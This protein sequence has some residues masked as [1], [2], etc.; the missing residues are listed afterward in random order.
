MTSVSIALRP[1][2]TA[3][4]PAV[5]CGVRGYDLGHVAYSAPLGGNYTTCDSL[6][7]LRQKCQSFAFSST[8]CFLYDVS[9]SINFRKDSSSPFWFYEQPCVVDEASA[10]A[11]IASSS[12]SSSLS[13]SSSSSKSSATRNRSAWFYVSQLLMLSALF[14]LSR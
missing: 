13:S 6:C 3:S 5:T 2:S 12:S 7:S 9:L 4:T 10:A 14:Q 8:T 1:T 11:K